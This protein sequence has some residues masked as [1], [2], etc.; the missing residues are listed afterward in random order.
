MAAISDRFGVTDAVLRTLQ[1]GS[2]I[3]LWVSTKEVPAV[4]DR[5]EQ[6]VNAGELP[7][8]AV[9]RSVVRVATMKR[10]DAAC[11]PLTRVR[12]PAIAYP[13]FR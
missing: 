10:N 3:A 5:L 9:D 1:A 8:E 13:R 6:A 2:D 11:S 12:R 7:V 4:L